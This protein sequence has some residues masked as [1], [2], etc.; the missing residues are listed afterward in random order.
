MDLKQLLWWLS[1]A[2]ESVAL[3]AFLLRGLAQSYRWFAAYLA[4]SVVRDVVLNLVADSGRTIYAIAWM[5][6]EPVQ[7]ILLALAVFE[8]V[9]K[10]PGYYRGFG[11]FGERKLRGLLHGA[12][13]IALLSSVI[14]AIGPGWRWSVST[15]LPFT[16][17]LH[18]LTTSVLA[19]YLV[20]LAIFVS[21]VPVPF[22][23]NLTVHSR[24]FAS[25]LWLQTG[26]MV[27]MG[28]IGHGTD[29]SS[30][31]LTGG[32][33]VLFLLWALLLTKAGETISVPRALTAT[34]IVKNQEREREL[35]E[36]ARK[37]SDRPLG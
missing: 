26:V 5:I 17:A 6:S 8:I 36:A 16:I 23:R 32:S 22:R 30:N 29:A 28:L 2:T 1:I 24:L 35:A 14:E 18:R 15:W 25:Y 33:T 10:I 12:L 19:I 34:E 9:G 27:W 13:A 4:V 37:Y 21:R 31:V 11:T 20:L 7:L 3:A